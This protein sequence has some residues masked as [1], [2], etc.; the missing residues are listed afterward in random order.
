[1][2]TNGSVTIEDG[3]KAPEDYA[4]ARKV[5]VTISYQAS[6]GEDGTK[7]LDAAA[8][9]AN[10]KVDELLGRKSAPT[11]FSQVEV[12]AT[13]APAKKRGA[14]AATEPAKEPELS[15]KEKL[16]VA[17]GVHTVEP[18]PAK[19]VEPDPDSL[20]DLLGEQA[21]VPITDA[22]LSKTAQN[23]N[24]QMKAKDPNFSVKIRALVVEYAGPPPKKITD[25]P[26]AKR[27][28]FLDKLRDL[29]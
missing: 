7:F 5:S 24:G 18:V 11:S 1:M 8:N 26:V 25:V 17:A 27:Q 21:P 3:N 19:I 9:A 13:A 2:N 6:E 23:R 15:D 4:P 12:P 29:T 10:L 16:A 28:E 20:D 22:E 14:K